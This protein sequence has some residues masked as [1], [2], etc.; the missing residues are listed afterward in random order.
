M[1]P[2]PALSVEGKGETFIAHLLIS[3][4]LYVM[5]AHVCSQ[6]LMAELQFVSETVG[7]RIAD[8]RKE[9]N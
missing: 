6:H 2:L 7:E 5:G 1:T 3:S 9:M 8:M 4:G